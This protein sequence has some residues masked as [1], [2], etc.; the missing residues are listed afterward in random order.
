MRFIS[1]VRPAD[2]NATTLYAPSAEDNPIAEGGG[3]RVRGPRRP[4]IVQIVNVDAASH[5][6]RVGVT[7]IGADLSRDNALGGYDVPINP[8]AIAEVNVPA[9]DGPAKLIVRSDAADDLLFV[10]YEGAMLQS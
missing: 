4:G 1:S 3:A 5:A 10:Y 8:Y 7:F 2:T 6:F 9:L